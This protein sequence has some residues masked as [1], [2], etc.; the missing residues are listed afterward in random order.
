MYLHSM[1]RYI[2]APLAPLLNVGRSNSSCGGAVC[3]CAPCAGRTAYCPAYATQ[4]A[5]FCMPTAALLQSWAVRTN[6]TWMCVKEECRHVNAPGATHCES[7][8]EVKPNLKGWLCVECSTRNHKGVKK[9]HKCAAPAEKSS[10]FWMCAACE[11]NNRIDDLDDN[12]CCGFCGYDMA[13]MTMTEAEA[14]RIQQERSERLRETQERFDA[15]SAKDADEQFGDEMAGASELPA[16]LKQ[17]VPPAPRTMFDIPEVK[18]FAPTPQGTKHSR[19]LRKPRPA[20]SPGAPSGPP[21]F[22]WMCREPSCAVINSGDEECCTGCG[23]H[24][25]P[26]EWECCHCGAVNHMTRAR[27]FNCRVTISIS[28]V[29]SDCRTATCIYERSCRACNKA[30]PPTEPKEA[31]DVQ[32]PSQNAGR[33]GFSA[34]RRRMPFKQDWNCEECQGLN[35]ASRTS[36]YQCGAARSTADAS[37]NGGASGGDGGFDGGAGLSVSHNNWF[38]RHCQA[39][40]FRTRAS[41]WQCGRASSESGA[42]TWS[43]D[44]S[45]PH[46]EKEG[47]QQTSDDNVAEGQV[48]VWNKK[49]DDWTCGKCFSKNFK[50]RQECH[51]CGATKTVAVAPRRAFVR[52]PVKI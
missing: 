12:S 29:C 6:R 16:A 50:N 38:C 3:F 48:N 2:R 28:W 10:E 33:A 36:C 46:F 35:F 30:R 40:N 37:Y 47:F 24:I 49:T 20:S 31:R 44:D 7:C 26:T 4:V 11:K 15:L 1:K 42:T 34:N 8:G 18:P 17:G 52:K 27:C 21:G 32:P 41:C 39:S 25:E 14:L 19:I 22:D 13:P 43:E 23:K 45:A 9:C 51:K 5:A